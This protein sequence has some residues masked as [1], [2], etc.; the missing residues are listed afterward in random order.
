M[1]ASIRPTRRPFF[2][3]AR[4]RFAATV[5]LPTPP[6]PLATAI[7]CRIP[8]RDSFGV[9][10]PWWC[11]SISGGQSVVRPAQVAKVFESVNARVV[12]V[13]PGDLVGVVADGRH[14]DRAGGTGLQ[15]FFGDD[16]E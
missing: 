6:L 12:S 7:T 14:G 4:A 13:V 11:M 5:D 3:S 16:V 9:T 1:S 2:E 10:P 8:G 15:F